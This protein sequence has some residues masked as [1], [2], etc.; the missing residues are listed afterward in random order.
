MR[1]GGEKRGNSRDRSARKLWM[2]WHFG[3][4]VQCQCVHCGCTL[5]Y[6]SVEAD[7]IVPGGSYRRDNVQPSCRTCNAQRGK[8]V[9]WVGPRSGVGVA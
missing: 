6:G 8:N 4:G 7:R 9:R 5:D 2:L 3:D 1:S